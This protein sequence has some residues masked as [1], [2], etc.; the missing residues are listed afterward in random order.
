M[1]P[2]PPTFR[3]GVTAVGGPQNFSELVQIFLNLIDAAL[4][5]LAAMALLVFLWGLVKFI[6]RVGGDE[7]AV[8]EGKSLMKWGLIALFLLV[9]FWSIITFIQGEVG[10]NSFGH[11]PL[12]P[13]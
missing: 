4:P 10:F 5:V 3:S 6:F 2:N 7:K 12:L 1:N 8:V 9:S 11:I 13:E